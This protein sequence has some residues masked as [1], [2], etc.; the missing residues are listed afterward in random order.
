MKAGVLNIRLGLE[1]VWISG[2]LIKNRYEVSCSRH[3]TG[4]IKTLRIFPSDR[5]I[6]LMEYLQGFFFIQI[7]SSPFYRIKSAERKA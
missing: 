4:I 1:F 7:D 5:I 2:N 6:I 3:G